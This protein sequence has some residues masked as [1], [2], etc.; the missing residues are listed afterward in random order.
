MEM[1]KA[2]GYGAE[3]DTVPALLGLTVR[4]GRW[5]GEDHGGPLCLGGSGDK[6]PWDTEREGLFFRPL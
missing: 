4:C 2:S 6:V 5:G 3:L 1:C